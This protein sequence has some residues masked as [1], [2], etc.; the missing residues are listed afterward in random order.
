MNISTQNCILAA[1]AGI[2]NGKFASQFINTK[3][4]GKVTIGGYPIGKEMIQAAVLASKR[5]RKEFILRDGE[6]T[7]SI[8]QELE[9]I[10]SPSDTIINLRINTLDD[11][12]HFVKRLSSEITFKPIIEINAHCQ[13]QE[14]MS[15]GG[16]QSLIKRPALLTEMIHVIQ[17]QDFAISLKI[18]ANQLNPESFSKLVNNWDLDYLHI[19]SYKIGTQGTDLNLLKSFVNQC[20]VAV[21]GNNSVVDRVSAK[22]ILEVGA[23]YFS[24]ARAARNNS[25]IFNEIIQKL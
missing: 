24:I 9:Y 6:E 12:Q 16:G 22:K 18:R 20:Q 1:M 11:I 13:Q 8:V 21:I 17:A 7:S 5:G 25:K 23:K 2:T 3:Q 19:D 14:F 15:I 10:K 4:V